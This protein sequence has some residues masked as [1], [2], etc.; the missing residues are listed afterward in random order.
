MD[1]TNDTQKSEQEAIVY[2]I[3]EERLKAVEEKKKE[4]DEVKENAKN[5]FLEIF[6][7]N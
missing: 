5:H 2:N 6:N 4:V 1:N 7:R 3:R